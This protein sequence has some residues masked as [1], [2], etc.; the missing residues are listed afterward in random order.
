MTEHEWLAC[1]DPTPMLEFL[2]GKAS[3]RKLRL[4][5]AGSARLASAWLVHPNSKAALE[6]CEKVAEGTSSPDILLP[7]HRAAWD[8]LSLEPYSDLHVA[9]A[10]AAGRAVQEQAYEAANLTK[11]EIVELNAEMEE[12]KVTS[13]NEKYRAYWIGKTR[14][15]MILVEFLRDIFGNPFHSVPVIP[16]W[17]TSTII[18]LAHMIYDSR[19]FDRLPILA[20]HLQDVGCDDADI[21]SHCRRPGPH[22]RGC[23]VVDL[24]LG[25]A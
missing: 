23:W 5:A 8:V 22:V 9:A 13:E 16:V 4:F 15:E 17:L 6:A 24:L 19:A 21:L 7:I 12:E 1:T 18:T 14:G 25:K 10:R 11:N 2:R 20:D 3:D